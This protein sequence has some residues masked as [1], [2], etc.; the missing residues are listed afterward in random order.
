M[1][2]CSTKITQA[3]FEAM[4]ATAERVTEKDYR[5]LR[6]NPGPLVKFIHNGKS[7]VAMGYYGQGPA[8]EPGSHFFA[9]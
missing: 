2:Q 8:G 1:T 4:L 7:V 9:A 6:S 5:S 3:D